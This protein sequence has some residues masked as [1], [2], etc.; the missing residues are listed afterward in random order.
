MTPVLLV[1]AAT[2][3]FS[4]TFVW[5]RRG[6]LYC[7]IIIGTLIATCINF[8]VLSIWVSATAPLAAFFD[9]RIIFF[10]ALGL[11]VPSISRLALL[12]AVQKVGASRSASL[13]AMSPFLASLLAILF[14]GE[15]PTLANLIGM[16]AIIGGGV[17]LSRRGQEEKPWRKKDLVYPLAGTILLGLRDVAIRFGVTENP[18]PV[19]GAWATVLISVVVIWLFWLWRKPPG[20][21][22]PP[23]EGWV[24][25]GL[26]GLALGIGFIFL[27]YGYQNAPVVVLSPISGTT[28][29]FTLMFSVLFLKDLEKVTPGLVA[30]CLCIVVGGVLVAFPG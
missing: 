22:A 27:F 20:Q 6:L 29:L 13:R 19:V 30:G 21:P 11:F 15:R 18:H 25:F 26:V 24:Y 5:A 1:V 14:L 7:D 16:F 9:R 23:L 3:L 12:A 2:I 10:F 28:P 8:V 4:S 17:L